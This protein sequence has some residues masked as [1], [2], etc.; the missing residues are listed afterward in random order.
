MSHYVLWDA[1]KK[2]KFNFP[3]LIAK[4]V[5]D[6]EPTVRT[7]PAEDVQETVKKKKVSNN[8]V[9]DVAKPKKQVK[10]KTLGFGTGKIL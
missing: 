4:G 3:G 5:S 10:K 1:P 7:N 2:E 6:T 9:E 8:A